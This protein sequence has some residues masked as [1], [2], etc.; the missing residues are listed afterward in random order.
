M[1]QS[2]EPLRENEVG[3]NGELAKRP[4]PDGLAILTVPPF[5]VMLP[6]IEQRAGRKL[7]TD[8]VEAERAKAPSIVLPQEAA[9]KMA[10]ARA[11]RTNPR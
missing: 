6:F 8:E 2:N 9:R 5:E 7:T 11:A 4:N 1:S 3:P 10:A